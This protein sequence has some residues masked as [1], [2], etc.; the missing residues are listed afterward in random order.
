MLQYLED[1]E[2]TSALTEGVVRWFEAHGEIPLV[3]PP[4]VRE[5]APLIDEPDC[6]GGSYSTEG[7]RGVAF[8]AEYVDSRGWTSI[9]TI[10]SLGIDIRHPASL[11][12]F[13]HAR[14]KVGKFRVDRIISIRELRS[15]RLLTSDEHVT[16]LAPYLPHEAPDPWL[17][18]LVDVQNA[19]RDGVYALLQLAMRDGRL[20]ETPRQAICGYVKSEA[21]QRRLEA[22][23]PELLALWIDNLSPPIDATAISVGRVLDYKD[24]FARLLPWLLEVVRS[25]REFPNP[26]GSLRNLIAAVRAHFRM[27]PH[28]RPKLAR[29]TS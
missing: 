3:P 14:G 10:R 27:S 17:C 8:V 16:L 26:E 25:T 24:R 4:S 11:T 21:K 13:C 2:A 19:T 12:A 9:S 5:Y 20:G 28:N 6:F 18:A 15:G 22:P 7:I 1:S 23:A 29:A